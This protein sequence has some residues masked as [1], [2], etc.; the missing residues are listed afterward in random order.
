M[1]AIAGTSPAL[2]LKTTGN[3]H[4]CPANPFRRP[5]MEDGPFDIAAAG[6]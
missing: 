4:H 2:L 5:A 6:T 1:M 3:R